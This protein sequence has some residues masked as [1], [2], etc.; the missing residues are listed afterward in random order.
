MEMKKEFT[1]DELIRMWKLVKKEKE[2]DKTGANE[3]TIK[4][5]QE[6]LHKLEYN[7][8]HNILNEK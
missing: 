5:Y 4:A 7:I 3:F 8:N 6:L 1:T 2:L